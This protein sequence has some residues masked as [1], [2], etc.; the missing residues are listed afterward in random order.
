MA[1][2]VKTLHVTPEEYAA[3]RAAADALGMELSRLVH[4]GVLEEAHRMGFFVGVEPPIHRRPGAWPD[5]PERREQST[6]LR[7]SV[8]YSLTTF[9]LL[10]RVAAYVEVSDSMFA[11]GSTLRYIANLKKNPPTDRALRKLK[12]PQQYQ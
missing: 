5:L 11:V 8:S 6:S 10:H 7:F 1:H 3:I 9:D 2:T 4:E 12:L